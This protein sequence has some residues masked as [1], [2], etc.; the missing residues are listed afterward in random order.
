MSALYKEFYFLKLLNYICM[1]IHCHSFKTIFFNEGHSQKSLE[2]T[3]VINP[4][5][6][7][8]PNM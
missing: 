8:S 4:A 3:D 6:P 5:V 1:C 2:I 7:K